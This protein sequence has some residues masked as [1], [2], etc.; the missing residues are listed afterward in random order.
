MNS[1][2][3]RLPPGVPARF[4]FIR[5]ILFLMVVFFLLNGYFLLDLMRKGPNTSA[6]ETLPFFIFQIN[7]CGIA[8]IFVISIVW[9]LHYGFGAL[10][11]ME[12]ILEQIINGSYGFRIHLRKR[13]IMRPF[14]EKLNKVL[15]ILEESKR[16]K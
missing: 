14:A 16:Q 8:L 5:I 9:I 13:D 1:K 11:R 6:V 3:G 2:Q 7:Y 15:D 12:S 10:S 4:K